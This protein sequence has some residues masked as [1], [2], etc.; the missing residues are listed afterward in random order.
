MKT[1]LRVFVAAFCV[2]MLAASTA[3]FAQAKDEKKPAGDKPAAKPAEAKPADT[4]P[5]AKPADTKPAE[6]KPAEAK[7]AAKPGDKPA[8]AGDK[9]GA[10]DMD[11]MM[12][13]MA[14]MSAPGKEHEALKPL[15]GSFTCTTKFYAAPGGPPQESTGTVERKWILGNRYIQE[16]VK[17]TM[18]GVPFEGF[19]IAGYDKMQK[20]YHAYWI[21]SMGTGTWSMTGTADATG[22][23]FT[24]TGENFDPM[25]GQKTKGRSTV[26]FVD[27][28][29][30]VMK[31]YGPGP[32]GKEFMGF[33]MTC[34]RK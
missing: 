7:P 9:G 1:G 31:M 24:Y 33:E 29:K 28:N 18:M 5:A 22:K 10:P 15:I 25:A 17:A 6:A 32:D 13:M 11:A 27:N 20:L 3:V 21:D 14:E 8:A 4:K 34:T 23:N 2:C 12:K 16:E 19:G 26:E 30:H